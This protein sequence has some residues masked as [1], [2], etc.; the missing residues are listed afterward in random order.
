MRSVQ[1]T[2]K[3]T[4]AMSLIAASKMRRAQSAVLQ[5]RPYAEKI[6]AVIADLAAQPREEAGEIHPLLRVRPLQRVGV[7]AI[8]PDRG[9]CGGL[10]SNLNRRVAQFILGQSVPVQ[11]IVVGRK[12]RDFMVRY[13]P[14]VKAVFTDLGDRPTV[15]DI[16]A[17]P[18]LVM[19]AIL[20]ERWTRCTWPTPGLSPP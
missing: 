14:D 10:H 13:G 2:G 5:G 6:Q 1:N 3:V 18:R 15:A 8:S 16:T 11:L 19:D 12:G 4:N 17:I 9:L 20:G 7:L